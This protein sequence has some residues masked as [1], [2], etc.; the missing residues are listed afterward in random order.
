MRAASIAIAVAL[1]FA[2]S[3]PAGASLLGDWFGVSLSVDASG[4]FNHSWT[5]VTATAEYFVD[6]NWS[7]Y[8]G[9]TPHGGEAFDI[10]AIYFDN[11]MTNAYIS[12]VTSFPMAPGALYLGEYVTPGDFSIDLGFGAYDVGV[13]VAGETG[14]IADTETADWYQPS[15]LFMAEEAPTNFTGGVDL[16]Y[17]SIDYYD[18]GLY[19]RGHKTYVLD[20]T[21]ARSALGNPGDGDNIGLGWTMGCR[22]DVLGLTGTFDGGPVVP[23]PGTLLLLGSGLLGMA[24]VARRR[25]K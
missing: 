8:F 18:Y 9:R 23:E 11:D 24:G 22:N 19:E 12:L 20:I 21:I 5:P 10:E 2:L 7:D 17:A 15:S 13:D 1:L 4:T 16:G 3:V 14:R 25:R 6:D